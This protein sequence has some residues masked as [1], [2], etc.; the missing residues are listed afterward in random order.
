MVFRH[1]YHGGVWVDLEQPSEEEIRAVAQEFGISERIEKE[2]LS[3][4]PVPLVAVDRDLTLLILHFPA[5]KDEG[6]D[7]NQEVD[8]IVGKRFII[9]V[10]YEVVAPL[11]HLKK[12][13]ETRDLVGAE[14][15]LTTE[16]LIEI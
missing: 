11:Y 12:L 6:E 5:H 4:T 1:A 10:R 14:D 3:P 16:M 15:S 2:L 8:F 9:T 13:L 7:D